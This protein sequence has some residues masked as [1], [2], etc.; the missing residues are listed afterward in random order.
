MTKAESLVVPSELEQVYSNKE[1][2]LTQL[3][4]NQKADD[5]D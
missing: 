4:A 3:I 5:A 1:V 2:M